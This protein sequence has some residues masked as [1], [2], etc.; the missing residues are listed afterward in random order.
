MASRPTSPRRPVTRWFVI[1]AAVI[2]VIAGF[3]LY[4]LIGQAPRHVVRINRADPELQ[5]AIK[6]A[7]GGL[8]H[9]LSVLGN[10]KLDE[11]FA[12]KGAFDTPA[13]RE[14]LWVRKP[15]YKD[16]RFSGIL[17]QQPMALASKNKGDPV[18]FPKVD[19]VDWMIKS[20][21][22]TEGEFTEKVLAKQQGR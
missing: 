8:G 3:A 6:Q 1:G 4:S 5:A 11:R 16:G 19:A 14:Y 9:F 13:G 18:S 21:Q 12:I 7:Q 2:L 15:V 22:G 17:D 20:D 10:P